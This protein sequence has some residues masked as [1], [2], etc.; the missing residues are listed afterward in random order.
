LKFIY[1]I[2]ENKI[3]WQKQIF[4]RVDK[5]AYIFTATFSKKT[6]KTIA[7]EVDEIIGSFSP[8]ELEEE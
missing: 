8:I 7:N 3:L 1:I 2:S 6:M 4:V 5:K